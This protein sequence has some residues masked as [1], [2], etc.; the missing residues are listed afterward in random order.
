MWYYYNMAQY[1]TL[2]V[3]WSTSQLTNL[4]SGTQNSTKVTVNFLPNEMITLIF[5]VNYF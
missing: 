3:K 2:N 1:K 4:K 5:L